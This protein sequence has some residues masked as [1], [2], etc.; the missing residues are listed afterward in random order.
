MSTGPA[1]DLFHGK[2]IPDDPRRLRPPLRIAVGT[3]VAI[4]IAVL[5]LLFLNLL[6]SWGV[7]VTLLLIS[8]FTATALGLWIVDAVRHPA[9]ELD[10]GEHHETP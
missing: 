7:W 8:A 9:T 3:G 4:I 1:Q 5:A 2:F 6:N 10:A